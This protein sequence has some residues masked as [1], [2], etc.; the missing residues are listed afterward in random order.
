MHPKPTP[1]GLCAPWVQGSPGGQPLW[2]HAPSPSH[3]ASGTR[4]GK[5][6]R[7]KGAPP[8]SAALGQGGGCTEL[9]QVL[10]SV[11]SGGGGSTLS[12]AA[13]PFAEKGNVELRTGMPGGH[14]TRVHGASDV[15]SGS[16]GPAASVSSCPR[17]GARCP[18]RQCPPSP[19][20]GGGDPGS[21]SAARNRKPDWE[22]SVHGRAGVC[23]SERAQP[24]PR[25]PQAC[26]RVCEHRGTCGGSSSWASAR[27]RGSARA[28]IWART[29]PAARPRRGHAAPCPPSG[30]SRRS[31]P[32][33]RG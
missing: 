3:P 12:S 6:R 21:E 10:R 8:R 29:R 15:P 2:P 28:V 11:C 13:S 20:S 27:L 33:S 1:A 25:G 32:S 26:R 4:E 22:R 17:W 19:A 31:A 14:A 23:R 18:R 24:S 5:A 9:W 30:C 16:R 7:G